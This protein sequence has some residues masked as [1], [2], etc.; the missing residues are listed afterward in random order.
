MSLP[1]L[2]RVVLMCLIMIMRCL[3]LPFILLLAI[4]A[5]V[6][7][8]AFGGISYAVS[9]VPSRFG[10]L[11]LNT[12]AFS[13]VGPAPASQ[14]IGIATIGNSVLA[15]YE[16]GRIVRIDPSTGIPSTVV[17]THLSLITL[18]GS[19]NGELYALDQALRLYRL[20]PSTGAPS[21]IGATNLPPIQSTSASALAASSAAIFYTYEDGS[22]PSTLYS[23]NRSTG[24]ATA[25]GPTSTARQ[26]LGAGY[27]NNTLYGFTGLNDPKGRSIYTLNLMN[28]A[29]TFVANTPVVIWGAASIP[30][31]G[32]L[33]L[34]AL[35]VTGATVARSARARRMR[36]R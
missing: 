18:A 19:P 12:G 15:G 21:L 10:I 16:N 13:P 9:P 22:H 30:E 27:I 11:D 3:S 29:A 34:A 8:H 31:P 25:L 1:N 4:L 20:N 2:S 7:G 5:A 17:D 26:I 24:L 36:V 6:P 33:G 35:A 14:Y 28:G 23:L 32:T